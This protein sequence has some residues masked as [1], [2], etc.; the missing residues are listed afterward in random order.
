MQVC[1]SHTVILLKV[2]SYEVLATSFAASFTQA[3]IPLH[4]IGHALGLIHEQSRPDRDNYVNIYWTSIYSY[5]HPQFELSDYSSAKLY[6]SPYDVGSVMHYGS[7][8]RLNDALD[9]M[10]RI[11]DAL[12]L[13]DKSRS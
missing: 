2:S 11:S 9:S 3:G 4:E 1:W 13:H 12:W 5:Y 8:V 6:G 7:T 10:V